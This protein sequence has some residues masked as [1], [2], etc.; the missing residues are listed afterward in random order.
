MMETVRH[1]LVEFMLEFNKTLFCNGIDFAVMEKEKKDRI[2]NNIY[3]SVVHTGTGNIDASHSNNVGQGNVG[4]LDND[5]IRQIEKLLA[6][7][8]SLDIKESEKEDIAQCVS[9]IREE[10]KSESPSDKLIR[11]ALRALKSFGSIVT[12]HAIG[13][14][15]D[16]LIDKFVI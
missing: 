9:D 15:I 13:V 12:E 6:D 8:D 3:A 1:Q 11:N 10:L 14:G 16:K 5:C 7:I 4:A 2:I